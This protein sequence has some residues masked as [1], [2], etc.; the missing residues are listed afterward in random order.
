MGFSEISYP[1][2]EKQLETALKLYFITRICGT[3]EE[4]TKWFNEIS[5]VTQGWKVMNAPAVNTINENYEV[6]NWFML[7]V[8][9]TI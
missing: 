1:S 2:V 9:V 7:A 3:D 5:N 8:Q 4:Y 6:P